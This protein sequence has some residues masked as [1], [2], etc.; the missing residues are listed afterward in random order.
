MDLSA[1]LERLNSASVAE[2]ETELLK[3]CGSTAW[4]RAVAARRPFGDAH[5]L[6]KAA[7]E[8]WWSLSERDWL[9]AFAAHPRIGGRERAARAQHRQAEGWSEQE[10]SG[11]RDAAQATLDELAAANR[12]YED[13]FGYIFIVCAT[14]KTADE[15]LG[16]LYARLPNVADAELR[17]AAAEQHKITSLRL[18]KLLTT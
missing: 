1:G 18:E 10:Q 2:A 6:L 4:A 15:M 11:A 3:C 8:I 17:V 14:G 13:K 16:L 9:E 5:E 7:E 12:A